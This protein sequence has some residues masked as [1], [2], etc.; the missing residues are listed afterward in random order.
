MTIDIVLFLLTV[1]F[2]ADFMFQSGQMANNKSTDNKW[3]T[4]HIFTYTLIWGG[5]MGIY[6]ISQNY[7]FKNWAVFVIIT[8]ISHWIT[9]YFTSKVVREKFNRKEYGADV[10]NL[11][12]FSIIG[13]DQL[14]HYIQIFITYKLLFL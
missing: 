4:W 2:V 10:P 6:C 3:L 7:G 13:F 1:H 8:F 5:I 11:G 12:A 14:L 9:D